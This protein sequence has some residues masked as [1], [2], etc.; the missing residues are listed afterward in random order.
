[1]HIRKRS[2]LCLLVQSASSI[3]LCSAE[4]RRGNTQTPLNQRAS[5]ILHLLRTSFSP[6]EL[7]LA[8]RH[9]YPPRNPNNN[10]SALAPSSS[11]LNSGFDAQVSVR[12]LEQVRGR[13]LQRNR[14]AY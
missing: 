10:E 1:M 5:H 8:G 7:V 11:G 9:Q 14:Y 4:D 3:Q 12:W 13:R 6:T 2:A